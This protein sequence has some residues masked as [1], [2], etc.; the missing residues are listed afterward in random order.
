MD[1]RACIWPDGWTAQSITEYF[2]GLN[3]EFLTVTNE[4]VISFSHFL[5]RIDVMP[6][7][8]PAHKRW[9]YPILG[10]QTLEAQIRRLGSSIHVYGH[11]HV[12]QRINIDGVLYINN[13]F[14]YPDEQKIASKKL[15]CIYGETALTPAQFPAN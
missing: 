10:T 11:S 4:T 15:L 7:Y 13:A 6:A 1:F 3:E 9:I 5:P 14:A 12:N 8:I 2:C